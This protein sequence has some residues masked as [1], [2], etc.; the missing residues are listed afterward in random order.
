M[1]IDILLTIILC[2]A[3]YAPHKFVRQNLILGITLRWVFKKSRLIFSKWNFWPMDASSTFQ[4]G[5]TASY[6]TYFKG[7]LHSF[8]LKLILFH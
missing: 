4:F 7:E 5:W 6:I 1:K 3:T 2:N 8:F